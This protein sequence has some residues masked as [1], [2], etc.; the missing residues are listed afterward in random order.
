M[1]RTT[2]FT[3]LWTIWMAGGGLITAAIVYTATDDWR[4]A[5]AA[6]LGSGVILNAVGQMAVQPFKAATARRP[7][8][9]QT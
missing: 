6:L 4:W 1:T 5:L 8:T 2:R 7:P 3:V 9:R